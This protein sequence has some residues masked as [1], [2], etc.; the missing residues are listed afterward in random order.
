MKRYVIQ[1]TRGEVL[2]H[3]EAK[4]SF[5]LDYAVGGHFLEVGEVAKFRADQVLGW[6]EI[7]VDPT[8]DH[9]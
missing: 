2:V 4:P 3:S 5:Q 9:E 7:T 8:L 6:H 1:T